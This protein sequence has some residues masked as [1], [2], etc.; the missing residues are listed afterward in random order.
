LKFLWIILF[1]GCSHIKAPPRNIPP[2]TLSWVKNFEFKTETGNLAIALNSP[3]I[4][5]GVLLMGANSDSMNAFDVETGRLFWSV[6]DGNDIIY[7]GTPIVYN[8]HVIY[9]TTT[10]RVFSRQYVTG[11]LKFDVDLGSSVDGKPIVSGNRLFFHLRNHKLLC[12]DVETGKVLWAFGRAVAQTTTLQRTSTPFIK[13]NTLFVGFAD[14]FIVALS[15]EE[16]LLL[17]ERKL[18]NDLKF[19][20]VDPSPTIHNNLLYAA[21]LSGPLSI[22]NP[23]TGEVLR[24]VDVT[25][26]RT[27]LFK[28]NKI[29]IPTVDGDVV[30]LDENLQ[31]IAKENFSERGVSSLEFY[32]NLL[33]ATTADGKFL[34]LD[35]LT[36]EKKY[37]FK[38]GHAYSAVFGDMAVGPNGLAFLTSRNRLYVFK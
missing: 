3:S 23:K 12:L 37:E 7:A 22:L 15:V 6:K 20:D 19:V 16:G 14:G 4:H 38:M 29:F 26:S 28:D 17:W 36:L 1:L 11:K 32:K 33:V 30:I 25:P 2:V 8:D 5:E 13:D 18:T 10:G 27:P 21:S 35:P 24:Q 9:G 31:I 34:V